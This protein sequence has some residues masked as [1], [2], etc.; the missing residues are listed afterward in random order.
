[1]S[2]CII[3]SLWTRPQRLSETW[4]GSH[5][6]TPHY[7][8]WLSGPL[9]RVPWLLLHVRQDRTC[10]WDVSHTQSKRNHKQII[11]HNHSLNKQKGGK[12]LSTLPIYL[13]SSPPLSTVPL[14]RKHYHRQQRMK[15]CLSPLALLL[16]GMNVLPSS[17][18]LWLTDQ[19]M[20]GLRPVVLLLYA[21][22]G[23]KNDIT[24]ASGSFSLLTAQCSHLC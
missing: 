2:P 13:E 24:V 3:S 5:R 4:P 19:D 23:Q 6:I 17:A 7:R 14:P 9:H 1:M 10:F 21:S 20:H 12:L 18:S 11:T 22:I 16:Q 15:D 8:E